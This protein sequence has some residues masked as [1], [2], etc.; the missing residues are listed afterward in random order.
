L[1]FFNFCHCQVRIC[2]NET[3]ILKSTSK[4]FQFYQNCCLLLSRP[5]SFASHKCHSYLV[6]GSGHG[7][8]APSVLITFMSENETKACWYKFIESRIHSKYQIFQ[9]WKGVWASSNKSLN[10]L[11]QNINT[12]SV[13]YKL[14]KIN[15]LGGVSLRANQL[16]LSA[17]RWQHG[18]QICLTNFIWWKITKLLITQQPLRLENK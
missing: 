15:N 9:N 3:E 16:P 7:L 12:V 8:E 14:V 10:C 13:L 18:F 5:K 17:S 11:Y 6:L 1:T 4:T 2:T